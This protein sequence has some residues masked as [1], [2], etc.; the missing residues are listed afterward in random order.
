MLG[1]AHRLLRRQRSR[2][3]P[4][5]LPTWAEQL[6][7]SLR[8]QCIEANVTL[9]LQVP[10]DVTLAVPEMVLSIAVANLVLNSA[11]HHY[12]QEN[13]WVQVQMWLRRA[14]GALVCDVRDN[15]PGLSQDVLESLFEPGQSYAHDSE[16]RHG[17]GLWLSRT[18]LGQ[19]GGSLT[20]LANQR[21]L[22]C[23]FRIVLPTL[24]ETLADA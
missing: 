1:T 19:E 5:H 10:P 7:A 18:L 2:S 8:R 14:D 21:C 16:K 15:G 22:G 17:I 13:R 20:L 4:L 11:K 9:Y 12:R 23:T 6:R 3:Q 24:T